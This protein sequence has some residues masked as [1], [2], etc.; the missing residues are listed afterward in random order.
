VNADPDAILFINEE[1]HVVIARADGAELLPR[2]FF[3]RRS[4]L[5]FPAV[6]FEK[7]VLDALVVFAA[8][9]KAD[10]APDV[11]HNSLDVCA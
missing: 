6:A 11:I 2:H 7:C 3:Q 10:D 9:A 8:N 5:R 4:C 1:V